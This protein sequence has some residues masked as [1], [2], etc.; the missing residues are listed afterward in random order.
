MLVKD[1]CT[2]DVAT[3]DADAN[4]RHAAAQMAEQNVGSLVIVNENGTPHGFL[5][6]RDITTA[7]VAQGM[8]VDQT[9]VK[10]VMAHPVVSIRESAE[11]EMALNCMTF[12][13][14]RI[15]VVNEEDR[16]VGVISL[17]DFLLMY[18]REFDH[19]RRVL[20]KELNLPIA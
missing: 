10:E 6:D 1:L 15:P 13:M 3:I 9:T 16:L 2:Q 8:D 12:G 5:T 14:R 19:V 11:M 7:V 4:I 18:S 20:Q 17:D